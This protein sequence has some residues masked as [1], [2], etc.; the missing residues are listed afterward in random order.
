MSRFSF[1]IFFL[2]IVASVC[3]VIIGQAQENSQH[4]GP[5]KLEI[6]KN[7]EVDHSTTKR[8]NPKD[9]QENV[10]SIEFED[11]FQNAL[12]IVSDKISHILKILNKYASLI[13]AFGALFAALIALYLG[14]WKNRLQRPKLQLSFNENK[15]YPYFHNLSFEPFG[16][17]IDIH[18]QIT[19]IYCPG[20]NAR[21]KIVNNGKTT[22]KNVEARVEKIEFF[23]NNVTISPTRFYHPTA[24]KWSGEK[25]WE[26]VDIVP[27]SHFFLDLFWSKNEASSEIYS[28]NEARIKHYGIDL[29]SKLLKE[30]ID[31]DI[32]PSQEV[33][34]NVWVDNSYERGLPRKYDIQGDIYIYFIVN[35]ENCVP[36][37]FEAIV[38]WSFDTWNS[39]DIK[40]R[41]GKKFINKD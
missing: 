19:D 12:S 31:K 41:M 15:Q 36:I 22:A 4:R 13:S 20:F 11:H 39:P 17:P 34:W 6:Q 26:P 32:Q 29:R 38:S 7:L 16:T 24:I 2:F 1:V 35:A 40:I 5:A 33:Y 18:G 30:I 10:K 23:K 28:F 37:K 25:D 3:P 8:K 14:D 9:N 21:V 27:E